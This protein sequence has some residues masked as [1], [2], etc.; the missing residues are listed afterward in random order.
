MVALLFEDRLHVIRKNSLAI[1]RG[2][3]SEFCENI[4]SKDGL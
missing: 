2:G 1:G 4:K 3:A